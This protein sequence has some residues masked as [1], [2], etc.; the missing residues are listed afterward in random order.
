MTGVPRAIAPAL[1]PL[2]RVF[3]AAPMLAANPRRSAMD[4]P[5][6][7][8][9]ADPALRDR[10]VDSLRD[11]VSDAESLLKA[12]HRGGE[13]LTQERE[14]FQARLHQVRD[15]LATMQHAAANNVR[16]AAHAADAAVHTHP[17]AAAGL[18]AGVGLLV[19][20]LISR[21]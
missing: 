15:E 1:S 21:R 17:Y 4:V 3:R 6:L 14:R 7:P 8:P 10:L 11:M 5:S 16:R 20:M 19:G 12:A 9:Q 2:K 13:P 18:A